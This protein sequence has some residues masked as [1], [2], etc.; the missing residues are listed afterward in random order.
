M[1]IGIPKE[2]RP[3]EFRV[4][5]SP[6]GVELLTQAGHTCYVEEGAGDGAGF[7]GQDYVN[8]GGQIVY[9]GFHQELEDLEMKIHQTELLDSDVQ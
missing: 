4:G 5:L 2:R 9:S 1:N 7:S 8:A 6:A 3:S